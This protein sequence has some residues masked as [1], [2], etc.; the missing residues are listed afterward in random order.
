MFMKRIYLIAILSILLIFFS[1]QDKKEQGAQ[2]KSTE[3]N[4]TASIQVNAVCVWDK[5][6]LRETPRNDGKWLGSMA[7]AE[8]LIYTGNS[9]VDSSGK[10]P[11]TFYQVKLS[12]GKTGWASEYTVEINANPAIVTERTFLYKRPDFLTKSDQELVPMDFV[13]AK[14]EKDNWV[15]VT[16][17]EK[18]KN[19]WVDKNSLLFSELNIA[20]GVLGQKA[21]SQSD[22]S[23][24]MD[25]IKAIIDNP[26][27]GSSVFINYLKNELPT[28]QDSS[29]YESEGD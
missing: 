27:F 4:V 19:G 5:G 25:E 16:G 23:K 1:C 29:L 22:S 7:L 28:Y 14:Q 6:S 20:V 13:A 21:L 10:R 18:K 8:K 24:R 12:D 11:A 26:A 15:E 17:A 2:T 3:E 9:K